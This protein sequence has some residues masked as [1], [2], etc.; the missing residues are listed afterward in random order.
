MQYLKKSHPEKYKKVTMKMTYSFFRDYPPMQKIMTDD[1]SKRLS[2]DKRKTL[3]KILLNHTTLSVVTF[4]FSV[5]YLAGRLLRTVT[6]GSAS[7]IIMT[8]MPHPDQLIAMCE[9]IYKTRMTGDILKKQKLYYELI[10]ILRSPEIL[11]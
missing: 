9:A 10:S 8:E 11:D 6:S 4:Y 5:V 3:H 1:T 2:T 7:N